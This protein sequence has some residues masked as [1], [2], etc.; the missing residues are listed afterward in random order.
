MDFESTFEQA[1][2]KVQEWVRALIVMLPNIVVAL[3]ALLVFWVLARV[4]RKATQKILGRVH[5]TARA[6]LANIAQAAVL[7]AGLVV[8]L[9]ILQLDAA[10]TSL[11]AGVGIVGLALGFAFQDL[12][13]NFISGVGLSIRR[14]L[15]PGDIIETNDEI[16]VVEKIE[17]R[18]TMMRTFNGDLVMI[19]NK[20]IY[21]TKVKIYGTPEGHRRVDLTVGISYGEDLEKVRRVTLDA[22]ASV[23]V[24]LDREPELFY[25]GFGDSSIDFTVRFWIS[26][27]KWTDFLAARSE[28][29]MRIKK[30]YD[31]NDITI[32]FPIRTLDFGIKGGEKL[33]EMLPEGLGRGNGR[34]A[35]R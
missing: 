4:V 18:S 26:F 19:P 22:I 23:E 24:R 5:L 12:A 15:A 34:S 32:P 10:V 7:A 9:S 25:E 14:V 21:Q 16:G 3:I 30:A 31:E 8:A 2:D 1:W 35:A 11:L 20:D 33:A 17:L 13:A 28:A 6:L 27:R 29:V